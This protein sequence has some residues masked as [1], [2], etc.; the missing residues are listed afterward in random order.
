MKS[1]RRFTRGIVIVSLIA[2]AVLLGP[3]L[4]GRVA[5]AVEQGKHDAARAELAELSGHDQLSKLF[6]A[7]TKAVK[8]AVVE[9]RVVRRVRQPE[10]PHFF[11]D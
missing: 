1:L 9:V 6:R 11:R 8:P 4:A 5:F 2:A 3:S 7:V 10:R